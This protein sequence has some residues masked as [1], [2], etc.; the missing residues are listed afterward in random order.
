MKSHPLI[1]AALEAIYRNGSGDDSEGA[2]ALRH[3]ATVYATLPDEP[4]AVV[5]CAWLVEAADALTDADK[6]AEFDYCFSE[7]IAK[8]RGAVG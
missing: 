5:P 8:L 7:L 4:L 1:W 3:L 2:K 6:L